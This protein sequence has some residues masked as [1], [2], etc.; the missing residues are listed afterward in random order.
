MSAPGFIYVLI[1]PSLD[2]LV[3]IGKTTRSPVNRVNELSSA[4][5][6]PTPFQ[7]VY[8]A[9]FS[10]CD[11]AERVLHNIFTE[12]GARVSDNREFFRVQAHEAITA[13]IS[14]QQGMMSPEYATHP[15]RN[16][17]EVAQTN[18]T[19][20]IEVLISDARDYLFGANG[21][22]QDPSKAI[23]MLKRAVELGSADACSTLGA[24]YRDY[25]DV[26]DLRMS[27]EYLLRGIELGSLVCYAELG[28]TFFL[29]NEITNAEKAWER[30]LE[31]AADL[32]EYSRG[33]YC[34]Y[35]MKG[36]THLGLDINLLP[37][38]RPYA[39]DVL[40]FLEGML[41]AMKSE[42][43]SSLVS[44]LQHDIAV[45]QY[46]LLDIFPEQLGVQ[47]GHI[48]TVNKQHDSERRGGW[49]TGDDGR[50]YVFTATFGL[51]ASAGRPVFFT[52]IFPHEQ[53]QHY[54]KADNVFVHL[55][56]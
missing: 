12:R 29:L 17:D 36:I 49:I 15:T 54:G 1:N 39:N 43:D 26:R 41:P 8:W 44:S 24:T 19:S 38:L 52:G 25:D 28:K 48:R 5:G 18:S 22:F 10:D 7:L 6:V 55:T 30:F 50:E 21:K 27:K 56:K 46:L 4:T 20:L 37:L 47:T 11:S 13:V 9:E 31:R 53:S 16:Y 33:M 35:C 32:T 3:K 34:A 23:A 51:P 42:N 14:L 2:G 40:R 45:T